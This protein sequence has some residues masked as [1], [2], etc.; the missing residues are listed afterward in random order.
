VS[1][2]LKKHEILRS[3]NKIQELF[4]NGSSFFLYPFKVFVFQNPAAANNQVLFSVSKRNFKSAVDR[5][6]MKSPI[7]EAYRLNKN[8]LTIEQNPSFSISIGLV[9]ISKFKLP[10]SEIES[11]LK[12]VFIRLNETRE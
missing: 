10:Y 1:Y 11:K 2:S 6:L 8:I 7:R 5:N 3:K 12:R 9:Y 4:E